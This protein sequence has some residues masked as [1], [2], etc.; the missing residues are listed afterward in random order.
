MEDAHGFNFSRDFLLSGPFC[1]AQVI[2]E[3][4]LSYRTRLPRHDMST[5]GGK[6]NILRRIAPNLSDLPMQNAFK[7]DYAYCNLMSW[8]LLALWQ[9]SFN[10]YGKDFIAFHM[11][12]AYL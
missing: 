4:Y 1:R 8:R 3:E 11:H 5:A 12:T 9:L 2:L 10:L 6:E 7:E